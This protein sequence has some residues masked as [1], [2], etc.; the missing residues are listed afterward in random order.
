[1]EQK[2]IHEGWIVHYIFM[3]TGAEHPET[4]AFIRKMVEQWK[5]KLTI[6]RVLVNPTFN[7]G[8]SFYEISLADM[9]TDLKPW[10]DMLLKY[11]EPTINAPRC[12]SRMKT[13]PHDKWCDS[14]F[15]RGNYVTWLGMRIDEPRRLKHFDEQADLFAK[16]KKMLRPIKYLAHLSDM[17]KSDILSWW[18][19]QPFDLNLAEHLGNCV[20]CIKKS[21]AKLILAAQDEPELAREFN[22][23][24]SDPKVRIL[25]KAKHK[26]GEIYRGHLS[27]DKITILSRV[28]EQD[29][30]RSTVENEIIFAETDP[31]MCSESCE[32]FGY[33]EPE[34]FELTMD[35]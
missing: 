6:I 9:K 28:I 35:E 8:V 16:N 10:K 33:V 19:K 7:V 34:E 26:P 3:D 13:E 29:N 21:T 15:G 23:V 24:L 27:M 5:I 31:T 14:K 4:Y 20:F 17:G 30:A 18:K 12:T 25:P 22:A 11:G 1:M 32:A 2:R